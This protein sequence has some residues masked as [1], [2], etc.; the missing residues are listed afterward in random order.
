MFIEQLH[1]H[2]Q[3]ATLSSSHKWSEF[4]QRPFPHRKMESWKYTDVSFLNKTSFSVDIA[5]PYTQIKVSDS[6]ELVFS[7]SIQK[8][9]P[10]NGVGY[11]ILCGEEKN[12]REIMPEI[13]GKPTVISAE[14][15]YFSDLAKLSKPET[16]YIVMDSCWPQ[17][18]VL[19]F[20]FQALSHEAM[21][22]S[23]NVCVVVPPNQKLMVEEVYSSRACGA[24]N[25]NIEYVIGEGSAVCAIKLDQSQESHLITSQKVKVAKNATYQM[26]HFTSQAQWARHYNYVALMGEAAHADLAGSYLVGENQFVDHHTFVDHSVAL[27][28]SQQVYSG[29]LSHKATGV[30]NGKVWIRRDSQKAN[31]EQLSRNLLL[32][33][34]AEAN[35][36]PE[37]LID[38]DDVKAKHG[39]TIGQMDQEELFYMQSR[40]LTPVQAR[41]MVLKSFVLGMADSL[42]T[43]LKTIF[44]DRAIIGI[45]NFVS[46]MKNV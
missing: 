34:S 45:N 16:I 5:F 44:F 17:N 24:L 27:T 1:Q 18:Q 6:G 20:N 13:E 26:V 31:A 19:K 15:S 8:T 35:T 25:V 39:A 40:G 14:E 22:S 46:D 42:P 11:R 21:I 30:Y 37:L 41:E 36:K 38:A 23:L 4:L 32:A 12:P 3:S 29:V 28:T 2:I 43:E 9:A 7:P 10:A 33:K